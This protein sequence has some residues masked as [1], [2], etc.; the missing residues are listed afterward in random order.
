M[1][2]RNVE[3]ASVDEPF[4]PIPITWI[5]LE[6]KGHLDLSRRNNNK[7]PLN[8]MYIISFSLQVAIVVVRGSTPSSY[9]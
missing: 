3:V 4:G 7:G 2:G 8:R 1:E 5:V 9:K 6:Q